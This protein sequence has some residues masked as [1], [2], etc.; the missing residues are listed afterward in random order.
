MQ[1]INAISY[2]REPVDRTPET[3]FAQDFET[4]SDFAERYHYEALCRE[5]L[6]RRADEPERPRDLSQSPTITAWIAVTTAEGFIAEFARARQIDEETV[7]RFKIRCRGRGIP[8]SPHWQLALA[9]GLSDREREVLR[10]LAETGGSNKVIGRALGIA[11]DTVKQHLQS[12]L[13][14]IG[15]QNRTQAAI[16][17]V[18]NISMREAAPNAS[19]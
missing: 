16:W 8:K 5:Y 7:A 10:H 4:L 17:A 15:A 18:T 3:D 9:R 13:L 14:K 12:I 1:L 11:D 6:A 2:H 19:P